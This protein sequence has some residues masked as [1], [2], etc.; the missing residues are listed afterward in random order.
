MK[1]GFPCW[2]QFFVCLLGFTGP[3]EHLVRAMWLLN[4]TSLLAQSRASTGYGTSGTTRKNCLIF[5]IVLSLFHLKAHL[6]H[7][8]SQLCRWSGSLKELFPLSSRFGICDIHTAC[9]GGFFCG[10]HD[11]IHHCCPSSAAGCPLL[12]KAWLPAKFWLLPAIQS[13]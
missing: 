7:L 9:L 4:G 2:L 1:S 8:K 12:C 10:I 5:L 11:S 6:Q 3:K 13:H